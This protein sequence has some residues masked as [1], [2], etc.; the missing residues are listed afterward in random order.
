MNILYDRDLDKR[1]DELLD[2]QSALA[3]AAVE[4]EEDDGED[5]DVTDQLED[6]LNDAQSE[7]GDDEQ[8]ELAELEEI[9]DVVGSE[10]GYG[11]ALIDEDDFTDYCKEMLEDCGE[12]PRGL[13]WYIE[14]AID[15]E[16][17]AENLQS[18]YSEVQYQGTTY[19]VRNT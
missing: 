2:L 12:L 9:K 7:F 13:P 18:D 17:V 15:W 19:L 4:L 14:N 11:A 8:E 6:A 10:W 1:L 5:Q 16:Q 3:E